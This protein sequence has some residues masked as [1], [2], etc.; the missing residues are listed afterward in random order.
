MWRR[1]WLVFSQAVTV[2][3]AVLFVVL[4]LK[5]EWLPGGQGGV[6]SRLLPAPTLLQ[7]SLPPDAAASGNDA[8]NAL[9]RSGSGYATA[10]RRAAPAVVSVSA[11]KMA[12][13]N[14]H[15]DPR[16]RFFFG[17]GPAAPQVGLGSAVIVSPEGYLLT[18]HHV[19]EDATEIEVQLADGRQARARLVGSDPETDIAVLKIDLDQLPVVALGD[20]RALQVGD[21]VLAIGNPFNVGQ[22]VTAGIVSAL[23]RSDAGTSRFQN[24]IQTDA[25]INP[26]NSGGALVDANGAL[27]G[28]NTAI[29]SRS[30][31]SL[32]IGFAVPADTARQVMEQLLR[33]GKVRRGWIGVEPRDLSAELAESLNLAVRQGVLIT[34]VLQNGPAAQGGLRPGDVVVQVGDKP[35]RNVGEL[36]GAVAALAPDQEAV[37]LAQRGNEQLRLKIKVGERRSGVQP[38]GR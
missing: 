2:A 34:G 18:N 38:A 1:T 31:G 37:V 35:V 7:M 23:D 6:A 3:V 15:T 8:G 27:V 22:T 17:D 28:I 13:N 11:T 21:A 30:G 29:F 14:P 33:D 12:R 10:A 4:T 25:A 19:V 24:F 9:G 36:F 16:F 20:V 5:P 32:G 26:G